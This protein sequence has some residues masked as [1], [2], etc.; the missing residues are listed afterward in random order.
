MNEIKSSWSFVEISPEA[1]EAAER[2]ASAAGMDLDA[3][4]A[5]LI[6]YT[7]AMELKT[8]P[9][10]PGT[11]AGAPAAKAA[12][13]PA[14]PARALSTP[15]LPPLPA[16]PPN[17][18]IAPAKPAASA[19]P[20]TRAGGDTLP[21]GVRGERPAP[22]APPFSLPNP[23][24]R[25]TVLMPQ[26]PGGPTLGLSLR[27][28]TAEQLAPAPE[29][30]PA[31]V[32]PAEPARLQAPPPPD[33][34]KPEPARREP[35]R[36]LAPPPAAPEEPRM[37][38]T[39][40]LQPSRFAALASPKEDDIQAALDKWRASGM[41]EP[42]IARPKAGAQGQFEIISGIDRWHAARRAYVRQIPVLVR[43]ASDQ[44]SLEQGLVDQLRRAPVSPLA[45]ANIYLR[46]LNDAGLDTEQTARL[47]GKP[48]AHVA[49][50]VRIL[51]LPKAVRAMLEKGEITVMHA[52]ALLDA[53]N[54]E[55]IARDIVEKRLDIYQTEQLVRVSGRGAEMVD[56]SV[57]QDEPTDDSIE[58]LGTAPFA[59]EPRAS[60]GPQA[61]WR[62]PP[63]PVAEAPRAD[64]PR[65]AAPTARRPSEARAPRES[66]VI[67]T[68]LLER[69]IA[70]ALG[71]R[72]AISE[73]NGVG[74]IT[75]HYT[76][77]EELGRILARINGG[78][79]SG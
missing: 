60:S 76:S 5:Q 61:A 20:A 77:R 50:M 58:E 9:P 73:R 13:A 45:E 66:D 18:S 38:P 63:E 55:A 42:L 4:L 22:A 36:D 43:E 56:A 37:V 64:E 65:P 46:L 57:L 15:P 59:R 26:R 21:T 68:D 49:T 32:K 29:A 14:A 23:A 53:P 31:P 44:Q 52:R 54:P 71:V 69:N 8:A 34:A 30:P 48:A 47:A 10:A 41:L 35:V 3:W 27:P 33:A 75:L 62:Q 78:G 11:K 6:K 79:T 24:P 39:D 72:C 51:N 12:Q 16:I 2:A 74:V 70:N 19:A 28:A 25:P 1:R 67:S 40:M 7:S 17:L